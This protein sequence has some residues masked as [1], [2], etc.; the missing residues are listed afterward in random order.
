MFLHKPD[1]GW[2]LSFT[3]PLSHRLA[4]LWLLGDEGTTVND[5]SG[6]NNNGTTVDLPIGHW[7]A[8]RSGGKAVYL[9][10]STHKV[11]RVGA[12][13]LPVAA[14]DAWTISALITVPTYRA[15][16]VIGGFGSTLPSST[17][18]V[19]R[20]MMTQSNNYYFYG[21]GAD[22][23]TGIAIEISE[24]WRHVVFSCDGTNLYFHLNGKPRGST[25]RPAFGTAGT[26]ITV[27]SRHPGGTGFTGKVDCFR[28]Y[29]RRLS[30]AEIARLYAEPYAGFMPPLEVDF[31]YDVVGGG[32]I[33]GVAAITIGGI[34][35]ASTGTIDIAASLGIT[36]GNVTPSATGTIA[37]AGAAAITLADTAP[38]ATGALD[39]VG[40]AAITLG[41]IS[42]T[43]EG[44]SASTG[45]ASITVADVSVTS[46][47]T[48]EI[49]GAANVTLSGV[50]VASA[51]A[52]NIVAA[53]AVTIGA[54]TATS[55]GA[56]DIF[57]IAPFDLA[58]VTV[59]ASG[60]GDAPIVFTA[61]RRLV[62]SGSRSR[63]ISA[64]TGRTR[65]GVTP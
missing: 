14:A 15:I 8:G 45:V 28:I 26:T 56:L 34:T 13:N 20:Y 37:I 51:S 49:A 55:T 63:S 2:P 1:P 59:D 35:A 46:T 32:D 44:T 6:N 53:S 3:D 39:I 19:Q 4:C 62:S 21:G 42:I 23:N 9:D 40:V 61:R 30:D 54:F 31:P 17:A 18:T 43:S 64:G 38:T 57:G 11:E 65:T 29:K 22:W 41:N 7:R 47:G 25:A 48:V 5:S 52:L 50:T 16:A 36:L 27:G 60:I 10:A 58:G 33:N 12:V 24:A